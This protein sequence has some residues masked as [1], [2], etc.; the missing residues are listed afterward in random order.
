MP[1]CTVS[2]RDQTGAVVTFFKILWSLFRVKKKDESSL[3]EYKL[4]GNTAQKL[5]FLIKD[6]IYFW[7]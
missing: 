3:L 7:Q 2:N 4:S 5:K 1:I 6:F